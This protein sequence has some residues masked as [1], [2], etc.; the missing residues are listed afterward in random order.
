MNCAINVEFDLFVLMFY[1]SKSYKL[2]ISSDGLL[3]CNA[4]VIHRVTCN[5]A[6]FFSSAFSACF[7]FQNQFFRNNLSGMS[8]GC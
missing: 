2:F 5:S 7:S 4:G 6:L 1:Q 8:S 3:I